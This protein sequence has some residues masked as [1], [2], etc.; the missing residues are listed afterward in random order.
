M[1]LNHEDI[2]KAHD[3]DRI[4]IFPWNIDRVGTNSYDVILGDSLLK[5]TANILDPKRDNNT[6][7]IEIP[8][9]GLVVRPRDFY[10][11]YTHEY[12][13]NRA[14]NIVP[15]I[16]GRS[17]LG[18]LGI[19]VHATAGFGDIG[20]CGRWALEIS[21]VKPIVIYPG[22][23]IAQLYWFWCNPSETR[24]HGKYNHINNPMLLAS[25]SYVDFE[26]E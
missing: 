11:A 4:R 15:M 16:E 24:Y 17:S 13:E 25:R 3:E 26:K 22:M 21:V 8:R 1:I 12:V 7:E 6:D 23:P 14:N 2:L 19:S 18:R 20:F 5:Y 10:I 9:K